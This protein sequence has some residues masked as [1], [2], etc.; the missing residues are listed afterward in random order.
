[1][2]GV[3]EM[4]LIMTYL[5]VAFTYRRAPQSKK[6]KTW[7]GDG[8]LVVNGPRAT[9]LDQDGKLYVQNLSRRFKFELKVFYEASQQEKR[10]HRRFRRTLRCI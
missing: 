9:L 6:H 5:S 7:Q 4:P 1:M 3:V 8:I 10:A 2:V